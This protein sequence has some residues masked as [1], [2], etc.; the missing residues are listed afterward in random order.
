M[1]RI[2]ALALALCSLMIGCSNDLDGLRADVESLNKQLAAL[3]TDVAAL[4]EQI[5]GVYTLMNESTIIVG[6]TATSTGWRLELSDGQTI[7]VYDGARI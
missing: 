4:N 3:E 6:C 7:V 2:L 5:I 1:K